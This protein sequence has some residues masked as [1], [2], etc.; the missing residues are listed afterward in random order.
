MTLPEPG[1]FSQPNRVKL[2]GEYFGDRTLSV[3]EAWKDVYKLLL[4]ADATTGLAHCYE[5]DKAQPGRPWYARTLAFHDWL[6]GEFG[7]PPDEL[8]DHLDWMFRHVIK[9]V[10]DEEAAKRE[11]LSKR[12]LEQRAAFARSLPRPDDDPELRRLIEPL[13]PEDPGSR[14]DDDLIRDVLKRIRTH[15]GSENKR[16]N[17]LGRGFE[18]VLA[19]VIQRIEGP[20][21]E[22][23]QTQ[24]ALEGIPGFRSVRSGDKAEKVDLWIAPPGGGRVLVSAKWSV[25]ADREK[26]M[27]GDFLTY[28]AANEIRA[29][30][31]FVWIT[32]E[33][34]PARLVANATNTEG[35]RW[36]LDA[37]VH[38]CP[39]ALR[40]VHQLDRPGL[41][42]TPALLAEQL[43]QGRII[44][45]DVWLDSLGA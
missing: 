45:L 32:N 35:N 20:K 42:R 43:D 41:Q 38:I 8:P 26:Q 12:A 19:G 21:P 1:P 18:D 13:L 3:T 17:L 4:W 7:V 44:G 5:S 40:V 11:R 14:P 25:R 16:K 30:F 22:I 10:A 31:E 2:I 36:L 33:F 23:L 15:I 29:P 9:K 24:A 6:A 28:V 37:V 34:D 39:Q 27:R